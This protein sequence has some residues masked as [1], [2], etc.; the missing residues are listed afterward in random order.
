MS[1]TLAF[2]LLGLLQGLTEFLPVSSSGHLALASLLIGLDEGPLELVVLLHAAT[3]GS[4]LLVLLPE[5]RAELRA[6]R[7][8]L[9]PLLGL[10]LATLVTGAIAFPL[11]GAVAS[12][13]GDAQAVGIGLLATGALLL[14]LR[15][16]LPV[17]RTEALPLWL[18]A[19]LGAVQGLA[20]FPGVSRSGAT[21]AAALWL[22]VAPGRAFALSFWL[23]VPAIAGAT[24]L[25]V[26]DLDAQFSMP[27][28]PALV[29]TGAAF[30]S[31]L[32]AL[33]LVRASLMQGKLRHFA[34]YVLP[35]GAYLL[36]R[37]V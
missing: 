19:L 11:K 12:A 26:L 22:G 10:G 25:A 5:A 37:A 23:S 31:G 1:D 21:L 18:Y 35:L 8:D 33:K 29:G 32:V 20:V 4:T 2:A 3:L 34:W 17:S 36:L 16:R 14:S 7:R 30:L 9:G 13:M 27:L 28:V 6:G 24:L 15:L